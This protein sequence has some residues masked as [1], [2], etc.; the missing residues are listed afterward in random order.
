MRSSPSLQGL[1]LYH[2]TM[3]DWWE[4]QKVIQIIPVS[5]LLTFCGRKSVGNPTELAT[6][7]VF[8]SLL[9]PF[10]RAKKEPPPLPPP[11]PR[12]TTTAAAKM[13]PG[14]WMC[15]QS[16]AC[17]TSQLDWCDIGIALRS[18]HIAIEVMPHL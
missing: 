15:C 6:H 3:T 7:P 18:F 14:S 12:T 17:E 1:L 4:N 8:G 13:H 9:F 16:E 10:L 5:D 11:P 2:S